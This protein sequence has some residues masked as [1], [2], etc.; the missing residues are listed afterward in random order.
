M[1]AW[2]GYAVHPI[3]FRVCW[4]WGLESNAIGE[5]P[6]LGTRVSV[7]FRAPFGWGIRYNQSLDDYSGQEVVYQL[8]KEFW[9]GFTLEFPMIS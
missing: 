8:R 6:C 5:E 4:R 7:T 1:P 9:V 3:A 2:R